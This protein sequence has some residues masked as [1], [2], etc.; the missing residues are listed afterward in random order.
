MQLSDFDY[1]LPSELIAQ[2]PVYPRDHSRLFVYDRKLD[3][4][5]HNYFYNLPNFLQKGDVLVVNNT[6]V[7]PA[8][9]K[10][11]KKTGGKLEIFLLKE[12][13]N[14][15]WQVMIGGA[16][17]KIGDTVDFGPGFSCV[18][19]EREGNGETWLVEFSVSEQD[20]YKYIDK[21]GE[22]PLPPYIHKPSS[23]KEYQTVYAKHRGSVAAPTAGFHFT[24]KLLE[25]LTNTGIDIVN[26]TLHV[27]LGTFAPVVTDDITKHKMHAE[28]G[29]ID[30]ATADFL[31]KAKADNRRVIAVGTTS[32]RTLETFSNDDGVIMA[33]EKWINTFIYPGVDFK[34]VEGIITNFHLPK[35][36][37]LML[38]S[39]FLAQNKKPSQ[40]I[41]I[42]QRLYAEAI[43]EK[44][45]FYSY[46][47]GMFIF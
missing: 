27:G 41:D 14:R 36:T 17:R 33:Q 40:G 23:H 5:S 34:F 18:L 9:L 16:K 45:R 39:A 19:V 1:N 2:E 4:I 3:K 28:W 38:V 44:Y 13:A 31:N 7:F 12:K 21:Y 26:I 24:N 47:D 15:I 10:G 20:L 42:L 37:L 32:V 25:D 29:S 11:K 30:E 43:E 35:S 6:K 8:R 46:G 22:V